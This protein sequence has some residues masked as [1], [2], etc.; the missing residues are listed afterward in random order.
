M[1]TFLVERYWPG[2][3]QADA[4][5]ATARLTASGLHVAETIVAATDEVCF[6]TVEAASPGDVRVAFA[7]A[8][9]PV[10]RISAASTLTI[11]E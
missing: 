11:H 3:I 5:A 9:I 8:G 2:L 1:A 6:W 10:D 7:T 4:A